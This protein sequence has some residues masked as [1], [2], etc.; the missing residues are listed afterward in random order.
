MGETRSACWAKPSSSCYNGIGSDVVPDA[1][2]NRGKSVGAAVQIGVA[3]PTTATQSLD[4]T[5]RT[6]RDALFSMRSGQGAAAF[7]D[8]PVVPS[9]SFLPRWPTNAPKANFAT[10]RLVCIAHGATAAVMILE[11]WMKLAAPDGCWISPCRR[12]IASRAR[13]RDPHRRV[14]F[15]LQ[16]KDSAHNPHGCRGFFGFGDFDGPSA[17]SFQGRFAQIM[18]PKRPSAKMQTKARTVLAAMGVTPVTLLRLV[19]QLKNRVLMDRLPAK[20]GTCGGFG[21]PSRCDTIRRCVVVKRDHSIATL[22]GCT[23]S[24]PH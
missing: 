6:R 1:R 23:A 14:S 15:G 16:A 19:G 20:R 10:A 7:A 11:A 9:S 5:A 22:L 4:A 21:P 2:T 24:R 13:S 3:I 17:T 8:T 12:R 18:P